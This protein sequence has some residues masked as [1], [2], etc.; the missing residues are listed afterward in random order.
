MASLDHVTLK[1]T[2]LLHMCSEDP[3][4]E[5]DSPSVLN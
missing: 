2:S 4:R 3:M 1:C 5:L